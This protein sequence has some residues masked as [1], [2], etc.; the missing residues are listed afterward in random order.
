MAWVGAGCH[1]TALNEIARL[2]AL[3]D[4]DT[5]ALAGAFTEDAE[6]LAT[7]MHDETTLRGNLQCALYDWN[8]GRLR[9]PASPCRRRLP[10][11]AISAP[12]FQVVAKRTQTGV[13]HCPGSAVSGQ[14]VKSW[15]PRTK[16]RPGRSLGWRKS[17][18]A[19]QRRHGRDRKHG[20]VGAI[21][22][23]WRAR[24]CL[25]RLV[26]RWPLDERNSYS[27]RTWT[28]VYVPCRTQHCVQPRIVQT[29]SSSQVAPPTGPTTN[30]PR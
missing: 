27:R 30:E 17:D 21:R 25:K 22:V 28:L 13:Q 8:A 16:Y 12:A 11:T 14:S 26:F 24:L 4:A 7:L 6:V 18:R 5:P 23:R 10:W 3:C 1:A 29:S 19:R 15:L 2:Y 9:E 20:S